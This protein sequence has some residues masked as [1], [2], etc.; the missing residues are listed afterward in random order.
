MLL[1]CTGVSLMRDRSLQALA[2][3]LGCEGGHDG[4]RVLLEAMRR[5]SY[6]S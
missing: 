1:V 4:A 5:A 6:K 2:R 3:E